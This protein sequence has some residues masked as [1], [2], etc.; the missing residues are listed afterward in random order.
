M[1]FCIDQSTGLKTGAASV[2]QAIAKKK[3]NSSEPMEHFEKCKKMFEY[4]HLLLLSD[5]W[6]LKF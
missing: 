6:W 5:I 2:P 4:Q 3:K 1:Q